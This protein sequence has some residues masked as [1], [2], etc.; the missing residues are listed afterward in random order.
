MSSY[1]KFEGIFFQN[2]GQFKLSAN[3]DFS[4]DGSVFT[5]VGSA[6]VKDP[7]EPSFYKSSALILAAILSIHSWWILQLP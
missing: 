6:K 5:I 7:A 3:S 2:E 4:D 1:P